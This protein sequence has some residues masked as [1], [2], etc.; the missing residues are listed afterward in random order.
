MTTNQKIKKFL[1]QSGSKKA[2]SVTEKELFKL[3][4]NTLKE[5]NKELSRIINKYGAKD[6]YKEM[7]KYNRFAQMNNDI[8]KLM[9]KDYLG[10]KKDIN[11]LLRD[12]YKMEYNNVNTALT[13][14]TGLEL[15]FTTL[16][17]KIITKA[18]ENPLKHIKWKDSL[19][20][21][22]KVASRE[23][24]QVIANGLYEG[25]GY[26]E[27]ARMVNKRVSKLTNNSLRI[28]RMESHR[29]VS[30]ARVDGF[31]E[32]EKSFERLGIKSVRKISSVLDSK[33]REQSIE[34]NGDIAVQDKSSPNYNMFLY[35]NG[36]YYT[37]PGMTGIAEYDIN[38]R[39][40]VIIEIDESNK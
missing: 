28:V 39:E 40:Q 20:F 33:T 36:S 23:I 34:V 17:S 38:D 29:I 16:D 12:T 11:G 15:S 37:A 3:Y 1:N 2:L 30:T 14:S 32:A 31:T 6:A 13:K 7:N 35:P 9:N 27:T 25:K 26:R 8:I 24:N 21:H 19:E 4:G 18:I 5:I 10:S 22:H